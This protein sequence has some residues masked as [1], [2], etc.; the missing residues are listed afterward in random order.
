MI[1]N[2]SFLFFLQ[3]CKAEQ[4]LLFFGGEY[5]HLVSWR[6]LDDK[7]VTSSW[8]PY[9]SNE[10]QNRT[11]CTIYIKKMEEIDQHFFE[12]QLFVF[13][14]IVLSEDWNDLF[15]VKQSCLTA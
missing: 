13:L 2:Q 8:V 10:T 11:K 14:P 15:L 7:I 3:L 1:L 9:L 6:E 5:A 4:D 12:I